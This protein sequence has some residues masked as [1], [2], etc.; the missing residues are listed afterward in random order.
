PPLW[1]LQ[2][3]LWVPFATMV[4]ALFVS[5][6]VSLYAVPLVWAALGVHLR[7]AGPAYLRADRRARGLRLQSV[8]AAK[9]EAAANAA[10]LEMFPND[11]SLFAGMPDPVVQT[12]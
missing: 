1:L 2:M 9:S 6:A 7:R 10:H 12:I 8:H 4:T 5:G 3:Q 11:R